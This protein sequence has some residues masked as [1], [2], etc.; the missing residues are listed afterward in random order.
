MTLASRS[1]GKSGGQIDKPGGEPIEFDQRARAGNCDLAPI[2]T[3]LPA[4]ALGPLAKTVEA[5]MS[6]SPKL[7]PGASRRSPGRRDTSSRREAR[8]VAA[9]S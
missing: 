4:K 8:Q 5:A 3:D 1:R 2:S 6:A 7:P 9:C